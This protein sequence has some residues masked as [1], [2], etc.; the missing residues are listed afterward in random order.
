MGEA[1]N[2]TAELVSGLLL[3]PRSGTVNFLRVGFVPL[4]AVGSPGVLVVPNRGGS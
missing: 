1:D 2:A 3:I 4:V